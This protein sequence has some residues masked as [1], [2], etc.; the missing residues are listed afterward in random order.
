VLF[1][2]ID[3][4]QAA[5]PTA[6]NLLAS[7]LSPATTDDRWQEGFSFRGEQCPALSLFDPCD[8][9]PAYPDEDTSPP[10]YV[11]P[12]G[13]RLREDCS[14]LAVG[15]NS[16]RIRR[17]SEA[18]ASFAVANELWTGAGT[19]ANP[20]TAAPDGSTINPFL[21]SN[22]ATVVSNTGLT[23]A[24]DALGL[25]EEETRRQTKG[26][27]VFLH[28]PL[29]LAIVLG[30]QLRRVGNELR[31]P[32]DAIVVADAGYDGSGPLSTGTPE[33]QT[34]TITGVP[35]GGTFTL[36][37]SGQT[38]AGIAFNAT[39]A[40]VRLAL[41]ALSNLAPGDV[42]VSGAAG[43]PYTV[44]FSPPEN[45]PQ[46]TASGAGLTGGTAPAVNVTTGTPG[47]DPA[48]VAGLWMY[49]TGPV[50]ARLGPI[51]VL[52]QP[53]QTVDRRTNIRELWAERMFGVGFDPCVHFAIQVPVP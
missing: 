10:V 46:M 4:F 6:V 41:E 26:Q 3:A 19:R 25:L 1:T 53:K 28:I 12:M 35:T 20:H 52:D 37:Y 21:A 2:E 11:Q 9:S 39:A 27:A 24:L 48:P 16:D 7:A 40:T 13:Y 36:T 8:G 43:G 18:T 49:G 51:A 5:A 42:A 31:T 50:V 32:T 33:V 38:T 14:T 45:V 30:A 34:V 15:M 44:T 23:G 29:R 47:V 17:M 22:D